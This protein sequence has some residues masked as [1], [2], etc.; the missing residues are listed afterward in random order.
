MA[1]N[2]YRDAALGPGAAG[3]L[4]LGGVFGAVMATVILPRLMPAWTA[5][6]LSSSPKAY[7]YL[8]RS[9]GVIAYLLLWLSLVLG[10]LTTSK[11]TRVW[12]G[13]FTVVDLHQFASWWGIALS[14]FHGLI[15]LGDGYIGYSLTE[16]LIPGNGNYRP[17]WVGLGQGAFY[18]LVLIAASFYLRQ[19]IG[20]RTW[21][22]LHY[23]SFAG[24]VLVTLHGL[25]AG[26]DAS[27]LS[28]AYLLTS[29]TIV[30]LTIFRVLVSPA[31]SFAGK[32]DL[33]R[34]MRRS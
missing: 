16:L 5:T 34:E 14:V 22:T 9:S 20:N 28:L 18:L 2:D 3:A 10:L 27:A 4:V 31:F 30:V 25:G 15:L 23:L 6:L 32:D 1:I 12:P 19:H 24:Y 29:F 17:V 7:W 26:T 8:S 13:V 33:T 21:R 11:S